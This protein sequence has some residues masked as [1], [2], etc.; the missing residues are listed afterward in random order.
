MVH[1]AGG[2]VGRGRPAP[3]AYV[4]M[5]ADAGRRGRHDAVVAACPLALASVQEWGAGADLNSMHGMCAASRAIVEAAAAPAPSPPAPALWIEPMAAPPAQLQGLRFGMH[6]PAVPRVHSASTVRTDYVD[7][8][9]PVVIGGGLLEEWGAA[10]VWRNRAALLQRH[11]ALEFRVSSLPTPDDTVARGGGTSVFGATVVNMTLA[12]F[13]AAAMAPGCEQ[14]SAPQYIFQTLEGDHPMAKEYAVP[15]PFA[16]AGI[17][18]HSPH[19]VA[20]RPDGTGG[21]EAFEFFAGPALSGAQPHTHTAAWNGL[22]AGRKQ[23][24][25]WPPHHS[26]DHAGSG[27]WNSGNALEEGEGEVDRH[28]GP[29]RAA[30]GES[31]WEWVTRRLEATRATAGAAP[32]EFVQEAGEVVFVPAGWPHAVLNLEPSIGVSVQ[33]GVAMR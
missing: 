32:I 2:T 10:T 31:A 22:V 28:I 16:D 30:A 3:L 11:G 9:R 15:P 14:G 5:L 12:A 8:G 21:R 17:Y 25:L 1:A 20:R 24:F 18:A 29:P 19:R 33:L 26:Q 23:W 13:V 4:E 6:H 27:A 7:A